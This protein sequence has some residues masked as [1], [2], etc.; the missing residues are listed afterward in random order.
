MGAPETY[1]DIATRRLDEQTERGNGLDTKLATAF[2]FSAAILPVFGALL[3]VAKNDRPEAAL[4][5]YVVAMGVY[6]L[7]LFFAVRAYRV[8]KFS[9]R[10]DLE[11]LKAN[12]ERYDDDAMRTWVAN[13]CV[14]SIDANE[15]R[16]HTKAVRVTWTLGLL[17]LDALL[18]TA[19]AFLV[20]A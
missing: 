19:A 8:T 4:I 2:G 18:L 13:E 3:A 17:A 16:L 11:T 10:P 7:M 9:L 5:L 20:L 12:C 15:P 6:V 14:L 1:Y